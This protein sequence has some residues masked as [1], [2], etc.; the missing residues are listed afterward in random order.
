MGNHINSKYGKMYKD[1]YNMGLIEELR[2]LHP[3]TKEEFVVWKNIEDLAIP[4]ISKIQRKKGILI[5]FTEEKLIDLI[6]NISIF[7]TYIYDADTTIINIKYMKKFDELMLQHDIHIIRPFMNNEM[8]AVTL[9]CILLGASLEEQGDEYMVDEYIFKNDHWVFPELIASTYYDD[10]FT[11]NLINE[12][13]S[14]NWPSNNPL[15]I[16]E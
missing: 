12:S 3:H 2:G 14:I 1:A 8:M 16:K 9:Q 4:I 11:M 10:F 6:K 5:K 13:F 7:F 15:N